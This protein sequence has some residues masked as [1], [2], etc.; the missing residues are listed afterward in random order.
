MKGDLPGH[1]IL[2]KQ[3]SL[4]I[5]LEN[6][7]S[8][9]GMEKFSITKFIERGYPENLIISNQFKRLG[10]I[11]P[12][13]K[14]YKVNINGEDWG[15]MLAE[16]HYSEV[17]YENRKLKDGLIFRL[18]NEASFFIKKLVLANNIQPNE[19][20]IKKQGNLEIDIS[21]AKK[22]NRFPHFKDHE[23][24]IKSVNVILNSDKKAEIKY[25][26]VKKIF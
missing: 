24:L 5:E 21:N 7:K 14:I 18:T 26:L 17:F 16:E 6:K 20:L 1:W 11:A 25:N 15:L 8:I 2:N 12:N 13:F 23:T 22:I 19:I 10:L 9:N 3:W 4:R